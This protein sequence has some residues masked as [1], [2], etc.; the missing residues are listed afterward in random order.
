MSERTADFVCKSK[1]KSKTK[2][3]YSADAFIATMMGRG[4]EIWV[5]W[6]TQVQHSEHPAELLS[7]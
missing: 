6:I 2:S 3:K 4:S 7:D 5:V 1:Y